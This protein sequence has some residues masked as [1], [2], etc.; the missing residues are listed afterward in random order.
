MSLKL[1]D[2]H[3]ELQQLI[4][5]LDQKEQPIWKAVAKG[6]NR[7][8]RVGFKMNLYRL[9]K[10]TKP[11]ET[12]VVPGVVLGTGELTK[13][14]TVAALKFSGASKQKIEKAGGKCLDIESLVKQYPEGKGVKIMG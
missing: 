1:R 11:K 14:L 13:P 12:I 2:K 5:D 10:M 8:R 4:I 6:I 3:Q 7:P 9:E